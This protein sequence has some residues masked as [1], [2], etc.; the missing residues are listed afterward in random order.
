M[1]PLL[2]EPE[3]PVG[4]GLLD[5]VVVVVVVVV[6]GAGLTLQNLENQPA[7]EFMAWG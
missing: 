5:E 7:I 3:A 4:P 6:F 1:F 2:T